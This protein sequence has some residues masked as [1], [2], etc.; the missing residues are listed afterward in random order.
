MKKQSL[1]FLFLILTTIGFT[2]KRKQ[3]PIVY[4]TIYDTQFS[5]GDRINLGNIPVVMLPLGKD[6]LNIPDSLAAYRTFVQ[7]NAL[8]TFKLHMI[9]KLQG[10]KYPGRTDRSRDVLLE[11]LNEDG[12]DEDSTCYINSF[13]HSFVKQ[14]SVLRIELEVIKIQS[15]NLDKIPTHG[16]ITIPEQNILYRN[17]NN[18]IEVAV[19]GIQDTIWVSGKDLEITLLSDERQQYQVRTQT[20][21]RSVNIGVFALR[22]K[23]TITIT[24]YNF[25]VSNLP[26]PTIYLLTTPLESFSSMTEERFLESVMLFAKYPPEIPMNVCFDIGEVIIRVGD[27]TITSYGKTLSEEYKTAVLKADAGTEIV[28]ESVEVKGSQHFMLKPGCKRIKTSVKG[29]EV[30]AKPTVYSEGCG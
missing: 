3:P 29:S 20:T 9:W 21:S 22:G 7:R 25:H 23:D 15:Y 26:Q 18:L 13:K 10:V 8:M 6:S 28:V 27:K 30:I 12:P 11:Y 24:H 4:K 2:Q 16:V 17:Y 14:D 1:L 19:S 5:V